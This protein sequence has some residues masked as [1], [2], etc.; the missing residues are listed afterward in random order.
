VIPIRTK[1]KSRRP[2]KGDRFIGRRTGTE[3]QVVGFSRKTADG[4]ERV[5]LLDV[6]T[7]V[8]TLS[9]VDTLHKNY[10][11]ARGLFA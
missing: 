9:K 4:I 2:A 10:R 11:A 6:D 1:K 8:I 3:K 5:K 7:G